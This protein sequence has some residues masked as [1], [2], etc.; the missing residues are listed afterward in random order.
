MKRPS[1]QVAY[2]DNQ[3]TT[4]VD[5]V[6]LDAMLPYFTEEYGNPHSSSHSYGWAA[7]AAV[8]QA[9][10]S[11]AA[12]CGADAREMV[13]TSGATE[14]CNLAIRGLALAAEQCFGSNG[15]G[16]R[17]IVTTAIEHPCV[18]ETCHDLKSMGYEVAVVGVDAD[19]MVDM[20]EL[21]AV[22]DE[23]TLMV[24]VIAA[25]NEIGVVQP[26]AQ[27]SAICREKGAI[28]HT[29]ATQAVGKIPVD[30][31]EWGVDMLSF[32]GH[33]IYAPKGIGVLYKKWHAD[34]S[35]VPLATGGGHEQG[36]RSGTVPVPLVVGLGE[37]CRV[38]SESLTEES[39][40]ILA[41]ADKLLE[42]LY[43]ARPDMVLYGH[44]EKRVPGNISV[45]F[46]G[47]TGEDVAAAVCDEIAISTGSA[48][49]STKLEPSHV[50]LA[51]GVGAEEAQSAV[52]ISL[53]RFNGEDDI[54]RAADVLSRTVTPQAGGFDK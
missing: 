31:A 11:I 37:A 26:I 5:P 42:M 28:L 21:R 33:K 20:D 12:M 10:T 35:I 3:A 7:E 45:G 54:L 9:R 39:G 52:R 47:L 1:P 25:N 2:L 17:K 14:S 36:L 6:V 50:L 16:R 29:D 19:G 15:D 46:P 8:E 32:S 51:L 53:G 38:I 13:F 41:M 44:R 4:P 22:V 49:S 24:S 43:S 34:A 40:R 27:I 30:V 48:C 18:L 23:K